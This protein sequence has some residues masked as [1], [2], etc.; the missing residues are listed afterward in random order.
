[1]DLN[2]PLRLAFAVQWHVL[3][4][5]NV[6][7][8]SSLV[9]NQSSATV[10]L[11][12][13]GDGYAAAGFGVQIDATGP[14]INPVKSVNRTVAGVGDTLTYTIPVPNT[15]TGSAENVVLRDSIP[16]GTTFVAGS[17]PVGGVNPPYANATIGIN[18]GS[19][20]NQAP[21]PLCR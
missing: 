5:T 21:Q 6:D 19:N 8:S 17:V 2:Q 1:G 10:R 18:L 13:D 16:N 3:D 7:A 11:V 9:N 4:I 15:V 20:S 12:P 14:I